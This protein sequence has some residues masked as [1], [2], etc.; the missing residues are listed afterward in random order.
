MQ[1]HHRVNQ[2]TKTATAEESYH[3]NLLISDSTISYSISTHVLFLCT[4]VSINS[5]K[6]FEKQTKKYEKI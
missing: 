4:H 6:L 3:L 5:Q 2:R 1:A